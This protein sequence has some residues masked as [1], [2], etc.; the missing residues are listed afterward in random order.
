MMEKHLALARFLLFTF[1]HSQDIA[2][3]AGKLEMDFIHP[4]PH[5]VQSQPLGAAVFQW[6]I[7][8]RNGDLIRIKCITVIHKNHGQFAV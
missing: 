3:V 1:D 2:T 5:D 6:G 4:L 7:D 8:V